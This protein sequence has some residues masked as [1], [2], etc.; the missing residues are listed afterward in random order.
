MKYTK[1]DV[2]TVL[3]E[4]G[5]IIPIDE[6][7][8][9]FN[10]VMIKHLVPLKSKKCLNYPDDYIGLSDNIVYKRVMAD[11]EIPMRTTGTFRYYLKTATADAIRNLKLILANPEIDYN[12]FIK[13]IKFYYSDRSA[14][15]SFA[16][17]ISSGDWEMVLNEFN[18]HSEIT[19]GE[20]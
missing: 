11:A 13:S 1:E 3:E 16:K 12:E 14:V 8:Y 19:K 2:I 10:A 18:G 4:S 9:L 15:K 17:F 5:L 20:L 6:E 7:K